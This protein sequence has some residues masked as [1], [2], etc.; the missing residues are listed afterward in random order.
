MTVFSADTKTPADWPAPGEDLQP[1]LRGS[2]ANIQF[3][4]APRDLLPLIQ[5]QTGG[6]ELELA[7]K[8]YVY[9]NTSGLSAIVASD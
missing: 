2:R 1:L 6:L 8:V 4:R 9:P 3:G 7:R 5:H